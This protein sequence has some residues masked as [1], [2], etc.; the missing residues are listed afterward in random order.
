M[1]LDGVE[2]I[3]WAGTESG[4]I[5]IYNFPGVIYAT[6]KLKSSKG[7][8]AGFYRYDTKGGGYCRV[9]R[10]T[11]G[12]SSGRTGFGAA[13]LALE[14]SLTHNKPIAVFIDL[15]DSDLS[16]T[17]RVVFSTLKNTQGPD[18]CFPSTC[19]RGSCCLISEF[20]GSICNHVIMQFP[21]K[22]CF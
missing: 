22:L 19:V 2:S 18:A 5:D 12:G 15:K 9:G 14:D 7:I 13:C 4:L 1:R 6:D 8:G 20:S 11:E 3:N 17:S 10:G 16:S 21:G